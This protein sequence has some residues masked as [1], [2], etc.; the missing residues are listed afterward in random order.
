M[1]GDSQYE[2]E[3]RIAGEVLAIATVTASSRQGA[4]EKIRDCMILQEIQ[5][6]MPVRRIRVGY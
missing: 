4:I 1:M 6:P 3:I 2:I 5:P